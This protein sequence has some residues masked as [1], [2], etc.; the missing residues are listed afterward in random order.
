MRKS[1][2]N[3]FVTVRV[4]GAIL[5]VDL[6]QRVSDGDKSLGGLNPADYH[7]IETEKLNE[8]TNRS[9]NRMLGA[10]AA[11]KNG[12]TKLPDSDTKT[13]LTRERW[14]LPLF[15]ELGY[16]RLN[17]VRA[18]DIDGKSFAVSH[19]WGSAP[20]HLVGSAIDLDTEL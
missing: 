11:F 10:W 12:L 4:E 5:P 6:L 20:I 16:G 18:I 2:N 3:Q 14:L 9:W 19:L 1:R 15:Q 13:S 7:L 17:T 8:A